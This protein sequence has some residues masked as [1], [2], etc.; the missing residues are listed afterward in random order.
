MRVVGKWNSIG[1]VEDSLRSVKSNLRLQITACD[2]R[3]IDIAIL[4]NTR[5]KGAS[6]S[7]RRF[8]F[9]PYIDNEAGAGRNDCGRDDRTG[10]NPADR[11]SRRC[12]RLTVQRGRWGH[13]YIRRRCV[14]RNELCNCGSWRQRRSQRIF[15]NQNAILST[16]ENSG[17]G[18]TP[19]LPLRALPP[20]NIQKSFLR[21]STL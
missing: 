18:S 16:D 8:G 7:S 10:D 6:L 20:S 15:G 9:C 5:F 14:L 12:G 2:V 17:T 1:V 3:F 19:Q 21:G 4:G 13:T 11:K